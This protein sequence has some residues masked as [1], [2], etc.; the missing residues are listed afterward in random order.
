M[1]GAPGAGYATAPSA[2]RDL[3]SNSCAVGSSRCGRVVRRSRA[4]P[5][6][7]VRCGRRSARRA[8]PSPCERLVEAVLSRMGRRR[9]RTLM[10]W[11]EQRS[12]WA[13][14][15]CLAVSSAC[16]ASRG[17]GSTPPTP[18]PGRIE[19]SPFVA[20]VLL[21]KTTAPAACPA[22][23]CGGCPVAS[24]W[25]YLR[26]ARSAFELL[27][28]RLVAVRGEAS[29][30]VP[31]CLDRAFA[32]DV[33]QRVERLVEAVLSRMGRPR[34]GAADGLAPTAVGMGA[35]GPRRGLLRPRRRP[36]EVPEARPGGLLGS[37]PARGPLLVGR[38]QG[39]GGLP[40]AAQRRVSPGGQG[41]RAHQVERAARTPGRG[42]AGPGRTDTLVGTPEAGR[43]TGQAGQDLYAEHPVA[44]LGGQ[45]AQ[46]DRGDAALLEDGDDPGGQVAQDARA[47]AARRTGPAGGPVPLQQPEQRRE[48]RPRQESAPGDAGGAE[49]RRGRR[50][51]QALAQHGG[52]QLGCTAPGLPVLEPPG[53]RRM[54]G[55]GVHALTPA[56]FIDAVRE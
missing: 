40:R 20:P 27:R 37:A 29:A 50:A 30:E 16:A 2:G 39:V 21:S 51:G 44:P 6:S 15:D 11:R 36:A 1:H 46:P 5:G 53:D 10:A 38:A 8:P 45:L 49:V 13:R 14:T 28:H 43:Q 7:S 32:V 54:V 31:R 42:E 33:V 26:R 56:R 41:V 48:L 3:R 35:Y 23:E 22:R 52:D 19:R 24:A 12:A 34:R 55:V 9:R 4:G 25:W 47:D 17:L 18:P